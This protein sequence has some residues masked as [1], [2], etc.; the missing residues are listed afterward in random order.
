MTIEKRVTAAPDAGSS[1][2]KQM[3]LGVDLLM[4]SE[5]AQHYHVNPRTVERW[6]TKSKNAL[7]AIR[8]SD[9]ELRALG[10]QG[11]ISKQGAY[12]VRRTDL[13]LIPQVRAYPGGTKRLRRGRRGIT[14]AA[15]APERQ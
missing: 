5:I 14:T 10:Y 3:C 4:T 15:N 8:V 13:A 7:P 9:D 2:G 11:N 1:D 12:L 6:I